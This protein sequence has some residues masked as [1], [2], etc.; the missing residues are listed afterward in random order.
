MGGRP[1]IYQAVKVEGPSFP[2]KGRASHTLVPTPL[3]IH[4]VATE[5]G[6]PHL[7]ELTLVGE[8]QV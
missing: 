8:P 3:E 2:T 6:L 5:G 4:Q 1:K 7:V